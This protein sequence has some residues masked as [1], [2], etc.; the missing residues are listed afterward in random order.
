MP[1]KGKCTGTLGV[2][3]GLSF[4]SCSFFK[5]A[6]LAST[7][8]WYDMARSTNDPPSSLPPSPWTP[9]RVVEAERGRMVG[10]NV[11]SLAVASA[12]R[13]ACRS[14]CSLACS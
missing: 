7:F 3:V 8:F 4:P 14:R 13:C 5:L 6:T 10:L 11:H 1:L 12:M 2:K 9:L